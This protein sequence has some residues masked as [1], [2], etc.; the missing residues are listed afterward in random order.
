MNVSSTPGMPASNTSR[1]P[2]ELLLA[3]VHLFAVDDRLVSLGREN[4]RESPTRVTA[5]FASNLA[6]DR[7]VEVEGL[8]GGE[9]L[10]HSAPP[11]TV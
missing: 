5:P 6:A 4:R 9:V 11:L 3:L 2:L 8:T 1:S 10:V 7:A